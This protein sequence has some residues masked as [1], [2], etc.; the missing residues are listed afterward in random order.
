[1]ATTPTLSSSTVVAR[2]VVVYDPA[3]G[4]EIG[5]HEIVV[6]AGSPVPAASEAADLAAALD[7]ME[8]EAAQRPKLRALRHLGAVQ[9]GRVLT[10]TRS[11]TSFSLA[12]KA[13]VPPVRKS[14]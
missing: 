14:T 3:T 13:F 2:T 9:P 4:A 12:Q 11:G 6:L 1:M 5:Q 8:I 10:L 7:A